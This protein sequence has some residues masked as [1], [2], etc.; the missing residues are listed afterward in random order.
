MNDM[1]GIIGIVRNVKDFVFSTEVFTF[2]QEWKGCV[3]K[4]L[5]P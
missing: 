5:L 4:Y 1:S 2:Q 3:N